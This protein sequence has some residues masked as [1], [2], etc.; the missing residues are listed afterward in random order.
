MDLQTILFGTFN[1][2]P[3]KKT[4]KHLIMGSNHRSDKQKPTGETTNMIMKTITGSKWWSLSDI[5]GYLG[6]SPTNI[7]TIFNRHSAKFGVESFYE[8]HNRTRL[9]FFRIKQS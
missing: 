8:K 4:T 6:I 3:I 7:N 2:P 5:S 9:K 1:P